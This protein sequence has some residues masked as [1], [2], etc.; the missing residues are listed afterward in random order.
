MVTFEQ[1]LELHEGRCLA[2]AGYN[3]N[4]TPGGI[5][6][7]DEN[8]IDMIRRLLGDMFEPDELDRLLLG[9]GSATENTVNVIERCDTRQILAASIYTALGQQLL[10]GLLLAGANQPT[11]A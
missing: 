1:A 10:M 6:Q 7:L 5:V 3:A 2:A 8:P 4:T 11:E 9:L